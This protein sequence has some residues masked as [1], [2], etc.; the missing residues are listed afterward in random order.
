VAE[1]ERRL[2]L[3]IMRRELTADGA[4]DADLERYAPLLARALDGGDVDAFRLVWR[5]GRPVVGIGAPIQA[6]LPGACR[7]LG[8]EPLIPKHADVANAVGAVASQVAVFQTVRV[9][10]GQFGGY[11]LFAPDG[12]EEFGRLEAAQKAGRE[13]VAELVRRRATGFGTAEQ[14]VR[15]EVFRHLGRLKDGSAQLLEIEIQ[16][17]LTGAPKLNAAA[18]T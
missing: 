2:A 4:E 7:R 18:T 16:G 17:Y 14:R 13:R 1:T 15:V 9:R 8:T 3:A 5:Q 12:R 6:F 10:P 11:V